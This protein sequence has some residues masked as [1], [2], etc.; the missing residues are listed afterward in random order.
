MG[1]LQDGWLGGFFCLLTLCD[2]HLA[3][4]MKPIGIGIRGGLG[5]L[6]V[7]ELFGMCPLGKINLP[8]KLARSNLCRTKCPHHGCCQ[9]GGVGGEHLRQ[10]HRERTKSGPVTEDRDR[11]M[12]LL[13]TSVQTLLVRYVQD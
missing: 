8:S 4:L 2:V 6:R 9:C 11:S 7:L 5:D 1:G 3:E 12:C 10:Q 13:T